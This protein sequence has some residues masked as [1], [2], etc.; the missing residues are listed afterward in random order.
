MEKAKLFITKAKSGKYIVNV[1]LDKNKTQTVPSFN[2]TSAELN[3]KDVEIE[4]QS[5]KIIKIVCGGKEIFSVS[6]GA[7]PTSISPCN[8]ISDI[9]DPA[10]APYNFV[11]LNEKVVPAECNPGKDFTFDKY[12]EGRYTGHIQLEIKAETP[13]YIRDTLNE[14]EIKQAYEAEKRKEKFINPD[15]F[16]PGGNFSI[17][18]SSLR[19]MTR[20]LVEIMS[21]GKFEFFEK[22]RK[23]HYRSFMDKS[24][25]LKD[26]Y[27]NKM[28][29]GDP[30]T[31]Y[32]QKVKA[33]Y[34]IKDGMDY[35]IK[36]AAMDSNGCQYYRVEEDDVIRSCVLTERMSQVV[37]GNRDNNPNY[38][39]WFKKVKFTAARPDTHRYSVNLKFSKITEICDIST[40]LSNSQE[41]TL[42]HTGWVGNTPPRIG[43]HLHW[44]IGPPS[45]NEITIPREAINDYKNDYRNDKK[46]DKEINLLKW[47][48]KPAVKEVPCFYIQE[49]GSVKSFGHT[50]LFRLAYDKK[51]EDFVYICDEHKKDLRD[52]PTAIFGNEKDFSGRVFF[53]DAGLVLKNGQTKENILLEEKQPRILSTPKPTTFNHY[54]CQPETPE[55]TLKNIREG[56]FSNLLRGLSVQEKN[57]LNSN[58]HLQNGRN[59]NIYIPNNP[60]SNTD[61][62]EIYKLLV[63]KNATKHIKEFK[64][65][66]DWNSGGCIR[67]NKLYWHRS[68]NDWADPAVQG[69]TQ[70]D[71]QHTIIRPIKEGVAFTGRIRFENL[72][73]VELGALL[74]AI[75]LPDNCCHK[76]GMGKPLG[77]GSVKITPTLHLSNRKERYTDLNAEW[78]NQIQ[79]STNKGETTEDF[80]KNFQNY[81]LKEL[82]ENGKSFWDIDRMKE[83]KKMLEFL[84]PPDNKTRYMT[85]TPPPNE[86]KERKVLPKP[87]EV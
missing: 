6:S 23:F 21:Y 47:L 52:I 74:S 82:G 35:K 61:G 11:P 38:K 1:I 63:K 10:W 28:V 62:T 26:A 72:S 17:P 68:G 42:V 86:F 25:K 78:K 84:G 9:V 31:G 2:P 5:G 27:N 59:G 83:L 73:R 56:E 19:G 57:L 32:G 39:I 36:P 65:I 14:A 43:K 80:K 40:A 53:E 8:H 87:S 30:R 76:I 20:T 67:G 44:V 58:F 22:D 55:P 75:A 13:L 33:G 3:G 12:H 41:G 77:L 29:S 24:S 48:E 16:S 45:N 81:V 70:I 4:R 37:N 71:D 50:G 7:N 51:V 49:N 34:L 18:G 64:K 79:L 66:R 46:R 60:I 54:L 15:F 85:I 69:H